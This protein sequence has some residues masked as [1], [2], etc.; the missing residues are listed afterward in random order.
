MST[1][2]ET[3]SRGATRG[4][5]HTLGVLIH[6]ETERP[7][8]TTT[9]TT[10]EGDGEEGAKENN[11]KPAEEEIKSEAEKYADALM[12][13]SDGEIL[14]ALLG[15]GETLFSDGGDKEASGVV[16]VMS[17]LARKNGG[18]AAMK[19]VMECV[20]ASASERVDLRVRC[21]ISLYNDAADAEERLEMFELLAAYATK[22]KQTRVLPMLVEH[23]S[24]NMDS[25]GDDVKTQRRVLKSCVDL[26]KQLEDREGELFSC[27]IKYLATFE[28]D[29]G[30]V[31]EATEIAKEAAKA[32]IASPTMFHGDFLA[33]KGVQQLESAD[34]NIFKVLSTLLTGTVSDYNA[35]VKGNAS[36]VSGLG[37]DADE[38]MAKMRMM[39]LSTLGKKGEVTYAEIKEALQCEDG[40]VEEWVVRAVGA[41]VIDAK[42]DQINQRVVFTRCTDRTFSG[43]EWKE[44]SSK[45]ATWRGQIERLQQTLSAK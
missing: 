39:G 6:G 37:L 20:T 11:D 5:A 7:E 42:M 31:G 26:L 35:L 4:A 8:P 22:A 25:W 28:N 27:M 23:A 43:A 45:I 44:L 16:S 41:S 21:A 30:A 3:S 15:Q 38:C 36:L 19:R 12:E 14:D 34:A 24:E 13:K 18:K 2:I 33:L 9:T 32:F 17:A 10:D 1:M 40:E 29:A